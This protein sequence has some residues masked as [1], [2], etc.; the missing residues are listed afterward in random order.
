MSEAAFAFITGIGMT[1]VLVV[2]VGNHMFR[3]GFQRGLE[4]GLKTGVSKGAT[5]ARS[6]LAQKMILIGT[7]HD[8]RKLE[9]DLDAS[10]GLPQDIMETIAEALGSHKII[11]V[12][13]HFK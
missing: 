9:R 13:E 6:A 2:I 1:L 7:M 8:I 12:T 10:H 5:L 11:D 4:K 3:Q